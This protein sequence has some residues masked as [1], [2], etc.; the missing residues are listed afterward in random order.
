MKDF[1][2][3][4]KELRVGNNESQ[5]DLSETLH[6]SFQSVSKWEQGVHYP[7]IEMLQKIANHYNV[8]IDYLLGNSNDNLE[9]NESKVVAME[10]EVSINEKGV[11]SVWTD[12]QYNNTI[13]PV[14]VD[15]SSRHAPGN[16]FLKTHPG[17]KDRIV[18]A[19]NGENKICLLGD[20]INNNVPSCGPTNGFIYTSI[21]KDGINNDCFIIEEGYG[22]N[23][24]M[25]KFEF[26]IP[27]DG[28]VLV[29]PTNSIYTKQLLDFIFPERLLPT[30]NKMYPNMLAL[31]SYE[32]KHLFKSIFAGELD[33]ITIR[34]SG[35]S[36]ILEKIVKENNKNE[37]ENPVKK[38]NKKLAELEERISQLENDVK[39]LLEKY[40][41]AAYSAEDAFCAAEDAS[42]SADDAFCKAEE[43]MKLAEKVSKI[44]ERA[45][46]DSKINEK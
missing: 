35:N 4:L 33:N 20:H 8:S 31:S 43:A 18:I 14:S 34:L 38:G 32:R 7:D 27:Q 10:L 40:K 42:C 3:V 29:I 5:K 6:I 44:L 19:V 46:N 45:F 36:V 2:Q 39:E 13:A 11:N 41:D 24:A 28:F 17:P 1:S 16:R 15:D 9:A 12:F 25:K 23:G 21:G 37:K 22:L 26:V 30:L